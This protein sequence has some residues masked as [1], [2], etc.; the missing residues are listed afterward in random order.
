MNVLILPVQDSERLYNS[1]L[2]D[3]ARNT[4]VSLIM[5]V[6]DVV[7]QY[8][9]TVVGEQKLLFGRL[10]LV[11]LTQE[12]WNNAPA[13]TINQR[14]TKKYWIILESWKTARIRR[15]KRNAL[16]GIERTLSQTTALPAVGQFC[17][18]ETNRHR[19]H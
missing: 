1:N 4:M 5:T 11:N 6:I 13:S 12:G 17:P 3:I 19:D 9:L 7:V 10:M 14:K 8:V 15:R 2:V 18:L 16:R